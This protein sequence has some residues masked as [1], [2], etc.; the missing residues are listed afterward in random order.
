MVARVPAFQPG[1]PGSIPGGVGNLNF[2]HGSGC[3][4]FA[5]VLSCVLSGGGPDFMLTTYSGRCDFCISLVFWSTVCCFSYRHLT[6]GHLGC[7]FLGVSPILGRINNK[8]RKTKFQ[9]SFLSF[10]LLLLFTLP[11]FITF[12]PRD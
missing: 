9:V 5:C 11:Q 4:S 3:V 12:T 1:G 8:E 2:C 7:M 6:H 10:F